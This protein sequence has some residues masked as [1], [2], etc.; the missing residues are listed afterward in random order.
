M[1]YVLPLLGTDKNGGPF[2]PTPA[3]QKRSSIGSQLGQHGLPRAGEIQL[4]C[5]QPFFGFG[6]VIRRAAS[7]KYWLAQVTGHGDNPTPKVGIGGVA[8]RGRANDGMDVSRRHG[9]NG[10]SAKRTS[11]GRRSPG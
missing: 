11:L 10:G 9:S 4:C 6:L 8:I 5:G 3:Q 2:D 7:F 1:D